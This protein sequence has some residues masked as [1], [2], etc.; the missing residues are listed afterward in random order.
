MQLLGLPGR[1][2][3]GCQ[4]ATTHYARLDEMMRFLRVA[5]FVVKEKKIGS[6]K[7][8][9]GMKWLKMKGKSN[10]ICAWI[11]LSKF[12]FSYG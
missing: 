6:K 4:Q 11:M 12:L 5:I 9:P 1:A 8:G 2:G 10:L 3:S 7:Q